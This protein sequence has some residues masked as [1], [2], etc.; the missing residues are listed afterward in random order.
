MRTIAAAVPVCP[1]LEFCSNPQSCTGLDHPMQERQRSVWTSIS[2][3]HLRAK[4]ACFGESPGRFR[5]ISCRSP[6]PRPLSSHKVTSRHAPA[7][8]GRER[9][10]NL[11]PVSVHLPTGAREGST[12]VHAHAGTRSSAMLA[13]RGKCRRDMGRIVATRWSKPA[14]DTSATDFAHQLHCRLPDISSPACDRDLLQFQVV[15][16]RAVS[17]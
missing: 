11:L 12:D 9:H 7:L 3:W 10:F 13:R 8:L 16:V 2:S 5:A 15:R 1:R 6:P 14:P 4:R 17:L